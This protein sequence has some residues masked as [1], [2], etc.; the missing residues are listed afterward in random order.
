MGS[1]I[2][3]GTAVALLLVALVVIILVMVDLI[4][5]VDEDDAD[6]APT[7]EKTLTSCRDR[8]ANTV[9]LTSI[10]IIVVVWQIVTQVNKSAFERVF[11]GCLFREG[12][13]ALAQDAIEYRPLK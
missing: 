10:K 8:L 7:W 2:D 5:V 12:A 4:R 1:S 13:T 9:P 6:T 3:I 11:D